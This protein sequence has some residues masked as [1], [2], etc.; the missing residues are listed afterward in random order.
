M[1]PVYILIAIASYFGMLLLIGYVTSKQ[2][3]NQSYFIGNHQSPWYVVAFGLIGDSLSGVT[4]ISLP[5]TIYYNQFGYLQLVLG[6][7]LGYIIIAKILL[8]IYYKLNLTSIYAYLE[9]RFGTQSQKT[10]SFFFLISRL[11]GAALRLYLAAGV[12]QIFVFNHWAIPFYVSVAIIIVLMLVYTYKGGIKTLV[13]TDVFQSI[14][15]LSGVVLSIYA[16]LNQ[17]NLNPAEAISKILESNYSKTFFWEWQEK[18]FFIKQFLSG[19]F[20]AVVMTGLDQNMMQKNLSVKT[21][22]DA[23]KNLYLFSVILV[24]VNVLFVS[25]GALMYMYANQFGIS[26]PVNETNGR[27]LTDE[28]FPQI[29]LGNL[30]AFAAMV[31]IIG[32]TAATF[33]SADSVLTTLTTSF[34]IDFLGFER[35]TGQRTEAQQ[36]SLRHKIHII[37]AIV[38]WVAIVLCKYINKTSVL[39]AIFTVAAYTYGPL[40]GLFAFGLFTKWQVKDNLVPFVSFVPPLLSYLLYKNSEAWFNGYKFSYELLLINGIFTFMGLM[41]VRKK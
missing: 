10:G 21:L 17:L 40:L 34:C 36:R 41:L 38:L 15:L 4:F 24:V 14:F 3:N 19:A 11:I 8:P 39:D 9:T 37:F 31:F 33:N 5:G 16:L 32:L 7:V 30:G 18:Q 29:A 20:I 23:Q 26:L 1:L 13:W 22:P 35:N 12:L 25:L 6:Y 2:A 27:I 28:V